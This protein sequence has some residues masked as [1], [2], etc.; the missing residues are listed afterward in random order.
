[1]KLV[2]ISATQSW[3][4][5]SKVNPVSSSKIGSRNQQIPQIIAGIKPCH[6][7][8]HVYNHKLCL[9]MDEVPQISAG[10]KSRHNY[11]FQHPKLYFQINKF[12]KLVL[13]S[14]ADS[15]FPR[16]RGANP[17]WG[18]GGA[19]LLFGQFFFRK[20]H[21]NEKILSQRGEAFPLDPPLGIKPH[22]FYHVYSD[23]LCLE[24]NKF[25]KLVLVSSHIMLIMF[26]IQNWLLKSK[27]LKLLLISSH[28]MLIM[29]T[30][31]KCFLKSTNY[32][33]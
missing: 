18:A 9:Q 7:F 28:V 14:V 8:Y 25:L 33:N 29:F 16:G 2:L 6:L 15:W 4:A 3:V 1:M 30:V 21:E 31:T 22:H 26:R 11:Y 12:L 13:V 5:T 10:I 24:I 32:W 23:K 27:V 20:L 19:N 17:K